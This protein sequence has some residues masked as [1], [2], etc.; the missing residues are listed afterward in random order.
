M[1]GCGYRYIGMFVFRCGNGF[2]FGKNGGF[3]YRIGQMVDVVNPFTSQRQA[4]A[5]DRN[6]LPALETSNLEHLS[7]P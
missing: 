2:D 7:N 1:L 4:Y 3:G 6:C 5:A